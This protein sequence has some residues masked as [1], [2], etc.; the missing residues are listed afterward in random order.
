[1]AYNFNSAYGQAV[2][3][4]LTQKTFGKTFIVQPTTY[5]NVDM[6]TDIFQPD[7]NGVVRVYNTISAALAATTAGSGDTIIVAPGHTETI[8]AAGGITI[9]KSGVS[10]IG[11]GKGNLR[12]IITFTTAVGASLN[13]TAANVTLQNLIFTCGINNQ[14]AMVNVT[15]VTD[16]AIRN[17][18]FNV[19]TAAA[20]A[21]IVIN[22]TGASDR[23]IVDSNTIIGVAGTTGTTST[24]YVTY[25]TGSEIQITNNYMAGKAT[26]LI[27]NSGTALRGFI[28]NNR[29]VVGTGTSAITLAAA[30]T[31]FITNNRINVASGTTPV[32]AAAGFV[33]GN[34]YSAA[35]DVTAGTALTW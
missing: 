3:M 32:T 10:I 14:T 34:A 29:L 26:Q 7:F 30:S 2:A 17:C 24:G 18:Y 1:M 31:P 15:A 16:V 35:A 13:I 11:M 5:P 12:P 33:A 4:N 23:L 8:T 6:I 28:D 9:A 21:A 19:A 27:N 25:A 22:A 20:G